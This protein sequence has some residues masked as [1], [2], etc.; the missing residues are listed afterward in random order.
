MQNLG[1]GI[2]EF[3][4]YEYRLGHSVVQETQ[5]ICESVRPAVIHISTTYLGLDR[6]DSGGVLL[7]RLS[8]PGGSPQLDL[9]HLKQLITID[10]RLNMRVLVNIVWCTH[11]NIWYHL[12][13]LGFVSRLYLLVPYVMKNSQKLKKVGVCQELFKLHRS[14]NL[15]D[16]L[17]TRDEKWVFYVN[18]TGTYQW[19]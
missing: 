4:L 16:N 6:F 11:P 13:Q 15:L 7:E 12:K 14:I 19:L 9:G 8:A 10:P 2:S 5:N 1:K 18:R 17:I 3:L